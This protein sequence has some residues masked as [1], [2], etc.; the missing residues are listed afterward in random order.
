MEKREQLVV[1]IPIAAD[2]NF[3]RLIGVENELSRLL[4]SARAARVE[5]HALEADTFEIFLTLNE[6]WPVVAGQVR[7][8]LEFGGH[9]RFVIARRAHAGEPY[10]VVWPPAGPR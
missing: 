6:P 2:T 4:E 5:S 9:E 3:D 1:R 8:C 7:A 10:E